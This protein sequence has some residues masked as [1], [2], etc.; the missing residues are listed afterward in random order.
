MGKVLIDSEVLESLMSRAENHEP[1]CKTNWEYQRIKTA[2]E[3]SRYTDQVRKT[4]TNRD[5]THQRNH[6]CRDVEYFNWYNESING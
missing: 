2:L 1:F 5:K 4:L 3:E 6:R